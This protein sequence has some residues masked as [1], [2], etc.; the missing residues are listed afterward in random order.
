MERHQGAGMWP[1]ESAAD[2]DRHY[3]VMDACGLDSGRDYWRVVLE[4]SVLHDWPMLRLRTVLGDLWP[5]PPGDQEL[6]EA[7]GGSVPGFLVQ[8]GLGTEAVATN[9]VGRYAPLPPTEAAA[10]AE[11]LVEDAYSGVGRV[12]MDDST[13]PDDFEGMAELVDGICSQVTE[14]SLLADEPQTD[15]R[16]SVD[17]HAEVK[18]L[19]STLPVWPEWIQTAPFAD[20]VAATKLST[21]FAGYLLGSR[22]VTDTIRWKLVGVFTPLCGQMLGQF[23]PLVGNVME[24]L[25]QT[26]SPKEENP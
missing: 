18:A 5:P 8:V 23:G 25:R 20:L 1:A 11:G 21:T 10:V 13:T 15:E 22:K 12:L 7:I 16:L 6:A 9:E 4:A 17:V 24:A 19:R 3:A 26:A 14:P 2:L